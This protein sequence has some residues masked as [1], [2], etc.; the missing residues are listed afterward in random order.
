MDRTGRIVLPKRARDALGLEPGVEL[1]LLEE[2]GRIVLEPPAVPMR[3]G[4]RGKDVVVVPSKSLPRLRTSQFAPSSSPGGDERRRLER[5]R[6]GV[7]E[8]AR[9]ERVRMSRRGS[10]TQARRTLRARGIL[11]ADAVADTSSR[12]GGASSSPS[13]RIAFPMSR[14]PSTPCGSA[15]SCMTVGCDRRPRSGG[16]PPRPIFLMRSARTSFAFARSESRRAPSSGRTAQISAQTS[17]SGHLGWSPT[18]GASSRRGAPGLIL[19]GS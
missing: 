1:D 8:L 5:R 18:R 15:G 9:S 2:D 13:C 6:G 14:S 10:T 11:R 16:T 19:T 7:C 4:R 17:S 3:L 12:L